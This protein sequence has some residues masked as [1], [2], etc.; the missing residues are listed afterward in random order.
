[1][2]ASIFDLF[3]EEEREL[4]LKAMECYKGTCKRAA[5]LAWDG[6]KATSRDKAEA[7]EDKYRKLERMTD[8][9]RTEMT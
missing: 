3:D 7:W 1:M 8:T 4:I 5:K 2:A 9:W 6:S